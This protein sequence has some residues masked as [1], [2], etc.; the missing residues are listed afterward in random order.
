MGI[1]AMSRT[2]QSR[3]KKSFHA[4]RFGLSSGRWIQ[5]GFF[6]SLSALGVS[7]APFSPRARDADTVPVPE[8]FA[9]YE[10]TGAAPERWWETFQS[11]E[12]NGLVEHALSGN[13]TLAQMH[14][15][16][17]QSQL[18]FRQSGG[19]LWPDLSLSGDASV[20]R[21][22]T[23]AGEAPID[24]DRVDQK[25][26]ALNTLVTSA[27]ARATAG[28]QVPTTLEE[29]VASLRSKRSDL[30]AIETLF[31]R[32]PST[33]MTATTRSYR[34]GLGSSY[35]VDLWGRVRAER[36]AARLDFEGSEEDLY[37]AKLSLS[38]AVAA[39]WLEVVAQGQ[40]LS[41]VKKQLQL[42]KTTQELMGL[43]YGKGMATALDVYQQR[44]IVAQTESLIPPLESG[45]RTG[46][47]ELAVLLGKAPRTELGLETETLPD[48][49]P[50][51][52]PGLP[53][54]LLAR[55]PDVR[56]AGLQLQSADWRVTAARADRLPALRLTASASYGAEEWDLVFDNWMATLAGS[57]TGPVFD[58]GRRKAEVR[59]ARAVVD[60]RLAAYQ[61][62][63][64]QAVNEVESA[65]F[66]ETKQAEYIN[67]LQRELDAARASHEQ[68]L[69]RYRKGLN[70]YLPVLSALS[71]LQV[72]ERKVLQAKLDHLFLRV[73]LCIALGGTWMAEDLVGQEG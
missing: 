66:R 40:E 50:L 6:V 21:R 8:T 10:T 17:V 42:N 71:E 61:E 52:E 16:L 13:L 72:L 39:Q 60:E 73:E 46:E 30:Q 43:R 56:G 12:L 37:A 41:L 69:G 35:E 18:L 59:R 26:G 70:D 31:A 15:R 48:V 36:Q 19:A 28:G 54:D 67:A 2:R 27:T 3:Y 55:R 57:L 29:L 7:C 58:A 53:A 20:T 32:A 9:L 63:V 38:G 49:G 47:Y 24:L 11:Q 44:Q 64:L 4:E 23:D 51:P 5:L 34:F 14:A 45:M 68:A 65:L 33:E 25:L 62:S 22:H 1:P